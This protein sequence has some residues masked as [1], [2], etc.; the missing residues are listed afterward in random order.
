MYIIVEEH[1]FK[2]SRSPS[3]V[4]LKFFGQIRSHILTPAI[5]HPA[6]FLKFDHIGIHKR[7]W[8]FPIDPFFKFALIGFPAVN[9]TYDQFLFHPE[10]CPYTVDQI[11]QVFTNFRKACEKRASVRDLVSEIEPMPFNN[12]LETDSEIP[13]LEDLGLTSFEKDPRTNFPFKGGAIEGLR[14][15]NNYFFETKKLGY[16]KKTRNGLSGTDYSSKFSPWLAHGCLSPRQIY[17]EVKRFEKEYYKNQS[18][19]WLIFEL[20]WRDYFKYISLKH[21]N[22]IFGIDGI[23]QKQYSWKSDQRE[24]QKWIDVHFAPAD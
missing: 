17:W 19:Y 1:G 18:T 8:R 24:L 6:R 22:K 20:I 4:D 23:L 7:F 3:P 5:A 10:D 9:E 14:R 2:I 15:L 16:Y 13:G 21:G 12:L 11:P